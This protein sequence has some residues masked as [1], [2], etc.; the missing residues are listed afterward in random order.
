MKITTLQEKVLYDYWLFEATV[1]NIAY[2]HMDM[3][4]KVAEIYRLSVE[5][6]R[7]LYASIGVKEL[8]D[9]SSDED[10]KQYKRIAEYFKVIGKRN[11]CDAQLNKMIAIKGRAYTDAKQCFLMVEERDSELLIKNNLLKQAENGNVYAIRTLGFLTLS[12]ILFEKNVSLGLKYLEQ[13]AD[14]ND[15]FSVLT[16]IKHRSEDRQYNLSRFAALFETAFDKELL[17]RVSNGKEEE[18]V[19]CERVKILNELFALGTCDRFKYSS[20]YAKTVFAKSLDLQSVKILTCGASA[21]LIARVSQLPLFVKRA[22]VR[23]IEKSL[24]CA[25]TL[26]GRGVEV[27]RIKDSIRKTE[28]CLND[29]RPLCISGSSEFARAIYVDA[30]S[31]SKGL[32]VIRIDVKK[33]NAEDFEKSFNNFFVRSLKDNSSNVVLLEFYGNI[34]NAVWASVAE[35]LSVT[36]L[37]QFKFQNPPLTFDLGEVKVFCISDDINAGMLA[38]YCDVI[39]VEEVTNDEYRQ[40]LCSMLSSQYQWKR[41]DV[42]FSE[43]VFNCGHRYALEDIAYAIDE[44]MWLARKS[45]TPLTITRERVDRAVVLRKKSN[46]VNKFGFGGKH[47]EN[48]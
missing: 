24:D 15:V 26:A 44:I 8:Y 25:K 35:Y 32:N 20:I 22:D 38:K 16:L 28:Y 41:K 34:G 14:W 23:A 42:Y 21:P 4:F 45:D 39:N 43:D 19:A 9:I 37:S 31:A 48:L 11:V 36:N 30:I 29:L 6:G 33:L 1:G 47:N 12:G 17:R 3:F 18:I 46:G 40:L 27:E 5:E 2:S 13:S 7:E 10:L